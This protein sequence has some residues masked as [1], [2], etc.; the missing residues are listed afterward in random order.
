MNEWENRTQKTQ[1]RGEPLYTLQPSS[2]NRLLLNKNA[3]SLRRLYLKSACM[4]QDCASL[5]GAVLDRN[6]HT[7]GV[8]AKAS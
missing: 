7:Q 2:E 1:M 5:W 3:S 8:C 4:W 6:T